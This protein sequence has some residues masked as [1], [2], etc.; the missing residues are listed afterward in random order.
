[1]SRPEITKNG[2]VLCAYHSERC[3]LSDSR[4]TPESLGPHRCLVGLAHVLEH[5]ADGCL[6]DIV[7]EVRVLLHAFKLH[8]AG[9][10]C[11][12]DHRSS[13]RRGH[14][15]FRARLV[16]EGLRTGLAKIQMHV[17]LAVDRG[18]FLLEVIMDPPYVVAVTEVQGQ[19]LSIADVD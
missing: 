5:V 10:A 4:Q 17:V 11:C 3:L 9:L 8:D 2:V 7:Y 15:Y 13:T 6:F 16:V 12:D 19:L 1:M 14:R 18:D